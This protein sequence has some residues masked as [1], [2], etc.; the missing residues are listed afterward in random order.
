MAASSATTLSEKDSKKAVRSRNPSNYIQ[1]K[2]VLEPLQLKGSRLDDQVDQEILEKLKSTL[3]PLVYL[4][5]TKQ[6][7]TRKKRSEKLEA[8][9]IDEESE[10]R[11]QICSALCLGFRSVVRALEKDKLRLLLISQKTQPSDLKRVLLTL[12]ATRDCPCICLSDILPFI[13]HRFNWISSITAMG[14]YKNNEY[15][16]VFDDFVKFASKHAQQIYLPYDAEDSPVNGDNSCSSLTEDAS[17]SKVEG[18]SVATEQNMLKFPNEKTKGNTCFDE[19]YQKYYIP[20]IKPETSSTF[21][22]QDFIS[23]VHDNSEPSILVIGGKVQEETNSR[24]SVRSDQCEPFSIASFLLMNV[25]ESVNS[26][27]ENKA[28][29][30]KSEKRKYN[31]TENEC[32][33]H[34]YKSA[35]VN[36][37]VMDVTKKKKKKK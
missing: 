15:G 34:A 23:F 21:A 4:N 10:K 12:V 30:T 19:D 16:K 17:S 1:K 22:N 7:L 5:R 6:K 26:V 31:S 11:K 29:G 24:P 33:I 37:I 32:G 3:D 9:P 8:L 27:T 13:Q 14:F 35:I 28:L 36:Q 2:T 18:N 20:A 25:K